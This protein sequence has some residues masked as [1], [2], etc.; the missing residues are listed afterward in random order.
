MSKAVLQTPRQHT[1]QLKDITIPDEYKDFY[2]IIKENKKTTF[3]NFLKSSVC[4]YTA[5]IKESILPKK[6]DTE[7]LK[8]TFDNFFNFFKAEPNIFNPVPVY[9]ISLISSLLSF[10]QD[11]E[12]F[13]NSIEFLVNF[14]SNNLPIS[15]SVLDILI[16][17]MVVR[18]PTDDTGKR[19]D[20]ILY[21]VESFGVNIVVRH[22]L[23]FLDSVD[24]LGS[25]VPRLYIQILTNIAGQF[26]LDQKESNRALEYANKL[27]TTNK[28]TQ[29]AKILI[30]TLEEYDSEAENSSRFGITTPRRLSKSFRSPPQ[31]YKGSYAGSTRAISPEILEELLDSIEEHSYRSASQLLNDINAQLERLKEFPSNRSFEPLF[32][33]AMKT[34]KNTK[35]S[36]DSKDKAYLLM[37]SVNSYCDPEKLLNYYL[38][39]ASKSDEEYPKD[40]LER[41]YQHFLKKS[42]PNEKLPSSTIIPISLVTSE[43]P[44]PSKELLFAF[45]CLNKW[46]SSYD[47][48]KRVWELLKKKPDI[49]I[50]ENFDQLIYTQK[51]FLVEGLR[52]YLEEE[53][54]DDPTN[55]NN[56]IEQEKAVENLEN[57]MLDETRSERLNRNATE[58]TEKMDQIINSNRKQKLAE[59]AEIEEARLKEAAGLSE[60]IAKMTGNSPATR[61]SSVASSAI[62]DLTDTASSNFQ[63]RNAN[64][65]LSTSASGSKNKVITKNK[66]LP[67]ADNRS[68]A[69]ARGAALRK[70]P[71][72][73]KKGVHYTLGSSLRKQ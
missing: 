21:L 47:G 72:L 13:S 32:N 11:K 31:R 17:V 45:A 46:E 71:T 6:T 48:V 50:T 56:F 18:V 14:I 63:E 41:C 59:T 12:C 4:P 35:S 10:T 7:A 23:D 44:E 67:S 16:P 53:Q 26:A 8:K 20:F 40:F 61:G 57:R 42:H 58:V 66:L 60:T 2:K 24:R 27:L 69:N 9:T 43:G 62:D 15:D 22:F 5:K 29:E 19:I 36:T 68:T 33:L 65:D 38:E 64:I 1:S 73:A 34:F 25:L 54:V 3:L 51:T 28:N 49:D 52:N 70:T 55:K 39:C 37:T 30:R